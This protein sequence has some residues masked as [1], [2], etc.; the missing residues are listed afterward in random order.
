MLLVEL[1]ELSFMT[2]ERFR[3][4]WTLIKVKVSQHFSS[5]AKAGAATD[6]EKEPIVKKLA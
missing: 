4:Q 2:W 6:V 5:I 1:A 3:E